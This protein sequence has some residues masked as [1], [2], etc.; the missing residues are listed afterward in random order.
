MMEGIVEL[1][2]KTLASNTASSP[3]IKQ[4]QYL[5]LSFGRWWPRLHPGVWA[6]AA[7]V[8]VGSLVLLHDGGKDWRNDISP[9]A[10]AW[11]PAP[12]EEGLPL[13]PY[14]ALLMSPLGGLPVRQATAITNTL[15]VIVL[16]LVIRQFGGPWW[17]VIP[18]MVSPSGI[19]LFTNG[20]TEW[21]VLSGL[22]FCNGLD[23]LLLSLKPQ[24]GFWVAVAR[25]RRAGSDWPRYITPAVIA[26][27]LSLVFWPLWPLHLSRYS[28]ELFPAAWNASFWPWSLPLGAF[29]VWRA[30]QTGDDRY[31][32]AASPLLFPYV[33]WP[34]YIGLLALLV[35][36]WPRLTLAAWAVMWVGGTLLFVLGS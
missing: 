16:A 26:V 29:L 19:W 31:G 23:L 8:F 14:A 18:V 30:W 25:L 11:W 1:L 28:A 33:N 4:V 24:V 13:P 32:L 9:A 2:R 15:A 5:P 6:F 27:L 3:A 22:L 10:R 20:Q 12:W 35:S 7:L 34:S 36:C 21:L 17:G